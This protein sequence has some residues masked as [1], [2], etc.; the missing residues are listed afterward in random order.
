MEVKM[1]GLL[2]PAIF[3]LRE[4]FLLQKTSFFF[5]LFGNNFLYGCFQCLV[6]LFQQIH[7]FSHLNHV[8]RKFFNFLKEFLSI[9]A[10]SI[11]SFS[12]SAAEGISALLQFT[13]YMILSTLWIAAPHS[14][15]YAAPA[16]VLFTIGL[17]MA[18]QVVRERSAFVTC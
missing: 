5:Y 15:Y 8:K 6:F 3:I 7:F 17:L 10:T 18:Y 9:S 4:C 11:P 13:G 12:I 1:A 2:R 16:T 14:I